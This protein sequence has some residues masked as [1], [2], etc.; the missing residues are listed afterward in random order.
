M[1]IINVNSSVLSNTAGEFGTQGTAFQNTMMEMVDIVN[2]AVSVW[3]GDASGAYIGKF[4]QLPD[5]MDSTVR[6]LQE[7]RTEFQQIAADYEQAEAANEEAVQALSGD[8]IM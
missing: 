4:A 8:V 3:T 2:G 7:C 6:M 5:D 1:A